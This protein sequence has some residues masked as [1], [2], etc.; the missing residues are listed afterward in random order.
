[1]LSPQSSFGPF[2]RVEQLLLSTTKSSAGRYTTPDGLPSILNDDCIELLFEIQA[3]VDDIS[4]QSQVPSCLPVSPDCPHAFLLFLWEKVASENSVTNTQHDFRGRSAARLDRKLQSMLRS[5]SRV[6]GQGGREVNL[7]DVCYKPFGKECA[8]QSLLQ[9]WQMSHDVYK[10]GDPRQ[11][12]RLSPEYCLSHWSTA[13]L[14]AYGGPQV[15]QS[16]HSQACEDPRHHQGEQ[17]TP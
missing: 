7:T 2:Y 5:T 15:L 8:T 9:Y 1:M 3:H 16:L 10:K 11:H 6:A 14:A 12:G 13:C 4:A 17:G